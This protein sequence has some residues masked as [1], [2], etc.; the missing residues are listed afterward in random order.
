MVMTKEERVTRLDSYQL[1]DIDEAV[2]PHYYG[3][4]NEVGN[5]YIL[6][7]NSSGAIRIARVPY[8]SL[9][10]YATKWGQRAILAYDYWY[11]TF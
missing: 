7:E 8:S 9:G 5:W 4:V 3:F 11:T 2:Y 1:Q 10:Q 6:R